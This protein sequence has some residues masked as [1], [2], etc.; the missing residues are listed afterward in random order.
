[1][2][3]SQPKHREFINYVFWTFDPAPL[4][5]CDLQSPCPRCHPYTYSL[6]RARHRRDR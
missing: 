5:V 1:M 3:M 6:D 2:D 4:A